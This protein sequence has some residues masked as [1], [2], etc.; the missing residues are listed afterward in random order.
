MF[1][2][3]QESSLIF[4]FIFQLMIRRASSV[5]YRATKKRAYFKDVRILVPESW[6]NVRSNLS[7]WET[8]SVCIYH[9]LQ[10]T[11][12]FLIKSNP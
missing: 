4:Y 6:S 7:T 10:F 3:Y 12:H 8:Y 11:Y 1:T 9:L 2:R 5:L